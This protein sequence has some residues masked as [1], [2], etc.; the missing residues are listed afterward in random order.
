MKSRW[1]V[2]LAVLLASCGG[3]GNPSL[4]DTSC[5]YARYFDVLEADSSVAVVLISPDGRK[6]DTVRVDEPMDNIIC[7]S[8]SH[9]AGPSAEIIVHRKPLYFLIRLKKLSRFE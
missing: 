9:V 7:M 5:L 6:R 3:G 2:I 8:S 1:L 4:P